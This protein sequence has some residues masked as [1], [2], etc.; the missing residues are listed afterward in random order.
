VILFS[1]FE[2][3]EAF[4]KNLGYGYTSMTASSASSTSQ[5][6]RNTR[7]IRSIEK[8]IVSA[9]SATEVIQIIF[10]KNHPNPN[11]WFRININRHSGKRS[12]QK[13]H[14]QKDQVQRNH[15]VEKANPVPVLHPSKIHRQQFRVNQVNIFPC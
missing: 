7:I 4:M 13:I 8:P 1:Y 2:K 15:P 11:I 10:T 3:F 5:S 14:S 9:T 6:Q 12:E